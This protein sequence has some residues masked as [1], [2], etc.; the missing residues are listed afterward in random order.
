MDYPRVVEDSVG[1]HP[2]FV[3]R[4]TKPLIVIIK[5]QEDFPPLLILWAFQT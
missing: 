5:S 1:F 3:H 2:S 4:A